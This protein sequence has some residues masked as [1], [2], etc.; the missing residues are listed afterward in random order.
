MSEQK[1]LSNFPM[2][3]I[4]VPPIWNVT[5]IL[6]NDTNIT[7]HHIETLNANDDVV[8]SI[9]IVGLG[10]V[11][12]IVIGILYMCSKEDIPW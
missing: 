11:M 4:S 6:E 9:V 12:M 10:F 2:S 3:I 8:L 1:Q 5:R 7:K